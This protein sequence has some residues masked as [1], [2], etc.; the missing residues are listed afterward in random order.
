MLIINDYVI[1]IVE[2][3]AVAKINVNV[4]IHLFSLLIWLSTDRMMTV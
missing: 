2:S 3:K 1:Q 4:S